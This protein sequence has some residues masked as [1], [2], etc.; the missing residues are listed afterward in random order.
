MYVLVMHCICIVYQ[1]HSDGYDSV[2]WYIYQP[3]TLGLCTGH[4]L[5]PMYWT[6]IYSQCT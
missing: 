6:H 5:Q 2:R 3:G 4:N 1:F